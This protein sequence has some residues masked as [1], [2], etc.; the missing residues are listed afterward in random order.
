[1]INRN[2][3]TA[4][5][6]ESLMSHLMTNP[7]DKGHA[8]PSGNVI[9]CHDVTQFVNNY[10]YKILAESTFFQK[11]QRNQLDAKTLAAFFTQYQHYLN[12]YQKWLAMAL[13]KGDEVLPQHLRA[14]GVIS[15]KLALLA[16]G[17]REHYYA[18]VLQHL[19]MD[20][21]SAPGMNAT[22]QGYC[23]AFNLRYTNLNREFYEILAGLTSLELFNRIL[24]NVTR[25]QL[26]INATVPLYSS[27][28][29]QTFDKDSMLSTALEMI[30]DSMGLHHFDT[31]AEHLLTLMKN[32]VQLHTLYLDK[33]MEEKEVKV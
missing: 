19:T 14:I 4:D 8:R 5:Y 9:N 3:Q 13:V 16:Q 31:K 12:R 15:N 20:E 23:E 30:V 26:I 18:T 6:S 22:T 11:M 2:T 29:D 17:N 28:D 10:C 32:E 27:L 24:K 7:I 21:E 33:L 25:R 1:M